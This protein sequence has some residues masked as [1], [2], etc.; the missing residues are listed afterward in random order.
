MQCYA[1]L[2]WV[3]TNLPLEYLAMEVIAWFAY[4]ADF[5]ISGKD[6]SE[7]TVGDSDEHWWHVIVTFCST[8]CSVLYSLLILCDP[9]C[10]ESLDTS[11][12]TLPENYYFMLTFTCLQ[13]C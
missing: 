6:P 13:L 2:K 8:T 5:A 9:N 10:A 3:T 12:H 4:F 11:L 1:E 7:A